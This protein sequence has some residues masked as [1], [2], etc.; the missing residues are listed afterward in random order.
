MKSRIHNIFSE[1]GCVQKDMLL[2]Y[3]DGE[4]N[5]TDKHDVERHL[6]DCELCSDALDGLALLWQ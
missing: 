5:D 1:T 2:K 3:R 4:L 6:I